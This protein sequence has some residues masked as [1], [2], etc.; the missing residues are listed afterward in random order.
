[1]RNASFQL[2]I[3]KLSLELERGHVIFVHCLGGAGRTGVVLA[4][5]LL[6]IDP[7]LES[8]EAL[9]MVD[10]AYKQRVIHDGSSPE[11]DHQ[12]QFVVDFHKERI[13]M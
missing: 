6:V 10:L 4:C 5:L 1:M 13:K 9:E 7:E 12:R 2:F 11:F 8:N 3:G